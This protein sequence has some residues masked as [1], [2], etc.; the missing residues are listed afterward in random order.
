MLKHAFLYRNFECRIDS[1]VQ[2][3]LAGNRKSFDREGDTER[4]S[5]EFLNDCIYDKYPIT[6]YIE[7]IHPCVCDARGNGALM[8]AVVRSKFK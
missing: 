6:T 4:L 1:C 5:M 7:C 3:V 2:D 8:I